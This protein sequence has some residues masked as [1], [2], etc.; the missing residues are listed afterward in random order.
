MPLTI[1][2]STEQTEA[3][4]RAAAREGRSMQDIVRTAVAQH[5]SRRARCRDEALAGVVAEDA[6]LLR[7]L[8][9]A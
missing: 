3:L 1:R 6:D 8:G 4:R 2:L 7:R 9:S 5:L